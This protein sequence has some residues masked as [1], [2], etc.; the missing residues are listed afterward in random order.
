MRMGARRDELSSAAEMVQ[1]VRSTCSVRVRNWVPIPS[2]HVKA[3]NPSTGEAET[4]SQGTRWLDRWA[5]SARSK[6]KQGTKMEGHQKGHPQST[7]G[8]RIHRWTHTHPC[9]HATTYEP[10]YH[11]SHILY[12]ERKKQWALRKHSWWLKQQQK[13]L[14]KLIL[15]GT[16][17]NELQV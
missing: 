16:K 2:T 3:C 5:E 15:R 7:S 6:F 8:L 9:L 1:R 13:V 11:H 10:T 4:G 17:E 12:K 14:N